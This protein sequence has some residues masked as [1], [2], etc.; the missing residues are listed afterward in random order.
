MNF[1]ELMTWNSGLTRCTKAPKVG[2]NQVRVL[3]DF[4]KRGRRGVPATPPPT[5]KLELVK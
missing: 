5:I 2:E 3:R 4:C 1:L